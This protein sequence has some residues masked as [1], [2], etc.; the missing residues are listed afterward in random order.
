MS[1]GTE[2]L[3]AELVEDLA[4]VRP[5]R[6]SRGVALA[7][8]GLT[9]IVAFVVGL[10]GLRQDVRLGHFDPVFL[11]GSGLFLLLGLAATVTVI[12]MSRPQVGNDHS[13]WAWAGATTA[14]LPVAATISLLGKSSVGRSP[15][16]LEHDIDCLL[17]GTGLGFVVL[18]ILVWWLRRGAPTSP[19]RAGLLAGVAAGSFGIFAFSL[20]CAINDIVHV[21]LWHWAVVALS[22]AIGRLAV[23]PLLH[24]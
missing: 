11:L 12:V 3:I 5:L 18:A 20:H 22:A 23:P 16:A 4:P 21:G 15:T 14:L 19:E 7:L 9:A 13:G 10:L 6:L 2:N 17:A 1:R 8:G 24:W